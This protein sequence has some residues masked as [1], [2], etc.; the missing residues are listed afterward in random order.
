MLAHNLFRRIQQISRLR[1]Q[2]RF[3]RHPRLRLPPRSLHPS[4]QKHRRS[5]RWRIRLDE[6]Q[7]RQRLG[8]DEATP[9]PAPPPRP[10]RRPQ[11]L[12]PRTRWRCRRYRSRG[13]RHRQPARTTHARSHRRPFKRRAAPAPVSGQARSGQDARTA[14][15]LRRSATKASQRCGGGAHH[16]DCRRPGQH[17]GCVDAGAVPEQLGESAPEDEPGWPGES[18]GRGEGEG[19]GE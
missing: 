19:H 16:H 7:Q 14:R 5:R 18:V 17:P 10:Q 6:A 8:S 12:R 11:R 4:A 2:P 15:R 1:P 9:L 13:N 3:R